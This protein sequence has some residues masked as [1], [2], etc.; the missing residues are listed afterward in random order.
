MT[1][2]SPGDYRS[3]EDRIDQLIRTLPVSVLCEYVPGSGTCPG[4]R[5]AVG[6]HVRGIREAYLH[7]SAG[8]LGL[9]LRG[10]VDAG[11]AEVLEATVAAFTDGPP[12]VLC[13]DLAELSFVDVAACRALVRGSLDLRASGGQVLLVAPAP[14]VE[15]TLRL[16]GLS[17]LPGFELI[18]GDP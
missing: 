5:D 1:A 14:P 15:R 7:T 9:V 11:N 17:D 10:E 4:L 2:L 3:A 16:L 6:V 13:L 8:D 12:R 18:G